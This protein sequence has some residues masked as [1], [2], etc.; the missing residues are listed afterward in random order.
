MEPLILG[1]TWLAV[2]WSTDVIPVLQRYKEL[3]AIVP[4]SGSAVWADVWVSPTKSSSNQLLAQQWIDFCWLP[5]SQKQI[6]ILSKAASPM[7][8]E[9]NPTDIQET[10]RSLLLV[11]AETLAKSEFLLPLPQETMSQIELLW[12]AM[13]P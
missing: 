9:I 13:K 11:E 12:Q 5:K 10:L 7:G 1:D 8:I 2:G 6:S 3:G 4:R